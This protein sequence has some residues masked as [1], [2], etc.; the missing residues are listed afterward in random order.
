[1]G[2]KEIELRVP[3]A[4]GEEGIRSQAL[5]SAGVKTGSVTV[6]RKSLDSRHKHDIR[7][8]VLVGV[9][10]SELQSGTEPPVPSIEPEYKKRDTH[11]LVIG[12]GPAGIFAADRLARSG[13]RVSVLERGPMVEARKQAI[14]SFESGGSFPA[15]ANYCFGEG[16]AGT[17]S[18]GKLSSRTKG[19]QP[20]R[21]YVFHRLVEAGAPAE[22]QAMTHP[23]V[24]SDNLFTITQKLRTML[25]E[26]G[27][28]F[29]FGQA[30]TAFH[31]KG[32][33]ITAVE[34]P[35][36]PV[37]ADYVLV[38][39]GHS[40]HDTQRALMAAGVRY[41]VKDFAI[42]FR[43]EHPQELINRAQWGKP[44]LPGVKAAEY[45]LACQA[46]GQ[47]VYSFC[48]CPGGTIV[49]AAAYQNTSVVN[50]K[51]DWAR[52]GRWANAAV[53]AAVSL[54]TL[55]GKELSAP[56]ALDWL[57]E[58]EHSYYQATG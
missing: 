54:P 35:Q 17:F 30:A 10:S 57:T 52:N 14:A 26:R 33:T 46:D 36:G 58:L 49:P 34:T 47:G 56:E 11:V 2:Y 15:S 48:M 27:V 55:L 37:E 32:G 53:V 16:G 50:G 12:T 23:H 43:A 19:I 25:Q 41:Q 8:Q 39:C 9:S 45:R 7:W 5:H 44:S 1:M 40:A 38:A 20:K 6:L 3:I 22:I 29:M 42:G 21:D 4:H 24:G 18:D 13:F 28:R 31:S 51:S